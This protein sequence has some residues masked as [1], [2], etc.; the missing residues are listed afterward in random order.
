MDE[1]GWVP[2]ALLANFNRIKSITM[3]FQMILKALSES[4]FLE[5][6][7]VSLTL[8]LANGWESWRMPQATGL[9]GVPR[10]RYF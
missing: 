6:D 5:V 3:D 7:T 10:W 2:I 1:A 4:T 9:Y 8:R